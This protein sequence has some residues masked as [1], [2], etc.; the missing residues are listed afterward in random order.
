VLI[1]AADIKI[2]W[3]CSWKCC[4]INRAQEY[5]ILCSPLTVRLCAILCKLIEIWHWK[6]LFQTTQERAQRRCAD[7]TNREIMEI[8]LK[9]SALN[10]WISIARL[11]RTGMPSHYVICIPKTRYLPLS[12]LCSN[13]LN[14]SSTTELWSITIIVPC[15]QEEKRRT[16]QLPFIP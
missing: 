5:V 12:S 11:R 9:V 15:F 14:K 16:K 7:A 13:V 8:W 10:D 6:L 1:G 3:D 2:K 4:T